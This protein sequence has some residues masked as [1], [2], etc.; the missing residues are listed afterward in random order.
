MLTLSIQQP[1]SWAILEPGILKDIENR[2]WYT[3]FRGTVL[4][5]AGKKID[6]EGTAYLQEMGYVVPIILQTGG[7]IGCV[8]IVDCVTNHKSKW[9]FGKYGFVLK[10]VRK[11]PFI[12]CRGQLGFFNVVLSTE[13]VY[14][15]KL[16]AR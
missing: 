5:H 12:A 9:F 2:E 7:I 3:N 11:L 16:K 6:Q 14:N 1:W 13:Y 10:N 8:D 15:N 4:V